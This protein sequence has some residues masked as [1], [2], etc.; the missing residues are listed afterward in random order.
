MFLLSMVAPAKLSTN[1]PGQLSD[2]TGSRK[3]DLDTAPIWT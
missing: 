3:L 1:F 2:Y